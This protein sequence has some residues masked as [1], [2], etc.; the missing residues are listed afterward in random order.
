MRALEVVAER[1]RRGDPFVGPA[2]PGDADA[3]LDRKAGGIAARVTEVAPEAL[4]RRAAALVR[5]VL[6]EPTVSDARDAPQRVVGRAAHPDR[7][8]PL[9]RARIEARTIDAMPA[10]RV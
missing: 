8:R 4:E 9:Y 3:T 2:Q 5:G 6:R 7:D 1:V 10:A